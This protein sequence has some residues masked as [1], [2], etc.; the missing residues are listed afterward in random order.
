MLSFISNS[1]SDRPEEQIPTK[2][3]VDFEKEPG[4]VGYVFY[5]AFSDNM[6]MCMQSPFLVLLYV[7]DVIYTCITMEIK[8]HLLNNGT[9]FPLGEITIMMSN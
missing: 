2:E 4:K 5:N 9:E 1:W 6:G 3:F 7:S 8:I